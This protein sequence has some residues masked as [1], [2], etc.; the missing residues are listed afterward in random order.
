[1]SL[2]TDKITFTI[3]NEKS[4]RAPTWFSFAS[5][6]CVAFNL[7]FFWLT[8]FHYNVVKSRFVCLQHNQHAIP[9]KSYIVNP[10]KFYFNNIKHILLALVFH[11]IQ[12]NI[13][14][15]SSSI[16]LFQYSH[17]NIVKTALTMCLIFGLPL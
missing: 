3:C 8:P 4:I 5:T 13:F 6:I 1:M 7:P 16:P 2:C 15:M 17:I 9:M 11:N 14:S 12:S 10:W